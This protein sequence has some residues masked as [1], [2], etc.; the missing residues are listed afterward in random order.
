MREQ[1]HP[2]RRGRYSLQSFAWQVPEEHQPEKE[3]RGKSEKAGKAPTGISQKKIRTAKKDINTCLIS[4][5]VKETRNR[6]TI[7]RPH[8]RPPNG[9]KLYILTIPR[10]AP[11]GLPPTL[12]AAS[13]GRSLGERDRVEPRRRNHAG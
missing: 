6:A 11:G 3:R 9:Q 13:T 7:T 2:R 5:A 10:T 8:P 12:V 4:F 1:R